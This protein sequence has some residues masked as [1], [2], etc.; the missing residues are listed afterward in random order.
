[1]EARH[2]TR[3]REERSLAARGRVAEVEVEYESEELR[4]ASAVTREPSKGWVRTV[5]SSTR[6]LAI[7][8]PS[9]VHGFPY[10]G[11]DEEQRVAKGGSWTAEPIPVARRHSRENAH[12]DNSF[13]IFTP[14]SE[15]G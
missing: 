4:L 9:R 5:R 3:K 7:F 13:V 6:K 14:T 1:M 2:E 12:L 10:G 11:G 15:Q 8:M